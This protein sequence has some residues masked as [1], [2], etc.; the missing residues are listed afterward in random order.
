[1][2]NG[3]LA[4]EGSVRIGG[5]QALISNGLYILQIAGG[6]RSC[7]AESGR[8]THGSHDLKVQSAG[9]QRHDFKLAPKS[10]SKEPDG[11]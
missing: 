5:T 4:Q 11:V 6:V 2:S 10:Q 9:M 8:E 1:M 7:S 3:T